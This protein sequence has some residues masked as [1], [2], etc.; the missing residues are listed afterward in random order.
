MFVTLRDESGTGLDYVRM[1]LGWDPVH[2][3]RWFGRRSKDIDLNASALL[4]AE[5]R[6]V[7]VVYHQQLNSTDGS[8]RHLGDSTTGEGKGD[9]E[10]IT[11]DLT[12]LAPQITTVIFIVTCYTGQ[13]F[14]QID[15][16]FCR[17]VDGMSGTEITRYDLGGG[18]SHTGLVM[19][20]LVHS[21]DGWQFDEIGA[22]IHAQ[23]PVEAVS[24]LTAFLI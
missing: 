8:V 4:F 19:G 7:D 20:K 18:G 9:N 23:H 1:A 12:R 11:V 6:L 10:I 16:A 5:D 22:A 24:Q 17:V 15:N 21:S 3:R 2:R 13:T 14:Q